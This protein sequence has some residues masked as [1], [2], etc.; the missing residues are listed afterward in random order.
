M[1]ENDLLTGFVLALLKVTFFSIPE[2][3]YILDASINM[4]T[5]P[6]SGT[7][8]LLTQLSRESTLAARRSPTL[9][10]QRDGVH[11]ISYGFSHTG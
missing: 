4:S 6:Y 9:P 5:L 7:S 2:S 1:R 3:H 10:S 11:H 8:Y